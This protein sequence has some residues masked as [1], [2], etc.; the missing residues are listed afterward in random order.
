[1]TSPDRER[2][3]VAPRSRLTRDERMRTD[4][5]FRD[6]VHKGERTRTPHF[7]IYRDGRGAGRKV[8]VSAGR[9]VGQAVLRNRLKRVLREFFRLEKSV[10]PPGTRT[11]IVVRTAPEDTGLSA[12]RAELLPAILKRWGTKAGSCGPDASR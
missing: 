4:R 10:F 9:R 8:G 6:V 1:M 3:G 5:E 2:C 12:V 7:T 11:A